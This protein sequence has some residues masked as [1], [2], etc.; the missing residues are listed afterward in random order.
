MKR[1]IVYEIKNNLNGK[2]YIGQYSGSNFGL[3]FGSGKLI[4]AAIQKYGL[5]N[6]TKSILEECT[7]KEE[8]NRREVYWIKE[9][10]AIENGY[11][12]TEGGTGGDTSSFINY[13]DPEYLEKKSKITKHYWDSLSAEEREKRSAKVRGQN[14]GMFGKEGYWKGLKMPAELVERCK[15]NRRSYNGADNPNWKGGISNSTCEVCD[16]KISQGA[17]RC[18][19][20]IKYQRSGVNNPFHGKTHSEETKAKMRDIAKNRT[21]K[22]SNS[23]KVMAEGVLYQTGQ[24]VAKAFG[25]TRGLVNYRCKSDKYDWMFVN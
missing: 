15:N 21:T 6:F 7:N 13:T 25:I 10:S 9:R 22:P 12:L 17:T 2:I 14:N 1:F 3:Y 18:M 4:K 24:E 8:L 5:E 23:K 20:H 11:N 19:E 16:K